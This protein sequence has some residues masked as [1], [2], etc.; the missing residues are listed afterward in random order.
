MAVLHEQRIGVYVMSWTQVLQN[1]DTLLPCRK[2]DKCVMM[3]FLL[4]VLLVAHRGIL[5]NIKL[6]K[7]ADAPCWS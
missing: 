5:R 4:S 6:A 7:G 2:L 1:V 3:L